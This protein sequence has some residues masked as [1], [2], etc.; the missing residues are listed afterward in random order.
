MKLARLALAA[1]FL[2]AAW[3]SAAWAQL[4]QPLGNNP[5]PVIWGGKQQA[6][7]AP[8]PQRSP[9][10]QQQH[11]ER[12]HH[13]SRHRDVDNRFYHAV[14]HYLRTNAYGWIPYYGYDYGYNYP[15]YYPYA[16]SPPY[17]PATGV[18]NPPAASDLDE[19]PEESRAQLRATNAA[20]VAR[21]QKFIG[22]GDAL[23]A[24][25]KCAEANDRYRKAAQAAPQLADAL[26]RQGFALAA[27]GRYELAVRAI[28]RGLA[29][30]PK[31]PQSGFALDELYKDNMVD[32]AKHL[33]AMAAAAQK[34]PND[35][36]PLFL[37]GVCLY[38]DGQAARAAPFLSLAAQLSGGNAEYVSPFLAK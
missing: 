35:A 8:P 9:P 6:Q 1:A 2:L 13:D 24:R 33:E 30:D 38:F 19:P 28:K 18:Y 37:I 4:R 34:R 26:F 22:Y 16:Y 29:L 20:S 25:G 14:A 15:Y 21:A 31:W 27:T 32:K 10:P 3:T 17:V 23:F 11:A 7:P 5:H 36:D 12:G